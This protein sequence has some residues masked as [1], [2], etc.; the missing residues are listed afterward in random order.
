MSWQDG[1]L[2]APAPAP[3]VE[4][5]KSTKVFALLRPGVR[6]RIFSPAA[7]HNLRRKTGHTLFRGN[8][9]AW[10]VSVEQAAAQTK[11]PAFDR[12]TSRA[13][14]RSVEIQAS[15]SSMRLSA[16]PL[17]KDARDPS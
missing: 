12:L 2:I 7:R 8:E 17:E 16:T 11:I 3:Q 9:G 10:Q 13:H 6:K 15:F 14:V 1:Q 4:P 5:F